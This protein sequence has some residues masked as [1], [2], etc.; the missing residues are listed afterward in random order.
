MVSLTKPSYVIANL[1]TKSTG[2]WELREELVLE[3]TPDTSFRTYTRADFD[4]LPSTLN[5]WSLLGHTEL[6]T[7]IQRFDIGDASDEALLFGSRG[8]SWSQNKILLNGFNVTNGDGTTTL[9]LPD[10]S[11]AG[12]MTYN[13]SPAERSDP[14]GVIALQPRRGDSRFHGQAQILFQSGALQNVN[15]TSRLRSF[16]I[17]ESDERFHYFTRANVQLGGP[18][19][20][21]W[22]YFGSVSRLQ[23]EKWV[24]NHSSPVRSNLTSETV[25]LSG[26]LNARNRLGLVWL[27]QQASQPDEGITP[28]IAR[29]STRDAIRTFQS[30]QGSWT[31]TLSPRNLLDARASFLI[32]KADAALQPGVNRPA[33]EELFPGSVDIPLVPSAEDGK[34]IVALLN[35]VR[36]GAAPLAIASRDRRCRQR[37]GSRRFAMVRR[38]RSTGFQSEQTWNGFRVRSELTLSRT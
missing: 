16:G 32:G 11:A 28:Q 23:V 30:L 7:T 35:H 12:S 22:N 1:D 20:S 31:H 26:D 18:L 5:P 15:V 3:H 25:H 17:T 9:L 4:R 2:K 19:S 38:P 34:S 29:E 36:T 8:G 27:G 10:P 14:G 33:S 24:R 37:H 13:A 21:S 6:S